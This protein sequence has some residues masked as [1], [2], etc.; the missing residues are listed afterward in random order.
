MKFKIRY[1]FLFLINILHLSATEPT[2][3][4][5]FY[6]FVRNDFYFNSRLNEE[7]IDGI[8]N[9]FPKPVSLN[10]DGKDENAVPNAEMI[11]VG[12]RLGMDYQGKEILGAKTSAKIEADFAGSASTYFLLRIRQAYVQLKWEKSGLLVGQAWHPMFGSVMP[13]M[14]SFNAG[15]PFQP[16][17]RSPQIRYTGELAKNVQYL[18][19]A[20][21][22]MQYTSNGPSG[23]SHT[24]MKN[25][26]IPNLYA[27]IEYKNKNMI[28]GI[29]IDYKKIKPD[30]LYISSLSGNAYIQYSKGMFMA[31]AKAIYGQN[32]SDLIMSGGYGKA[33]DVSSQTY[34]YTNFNSMTGWINLV[35][36]KK[37]QTG[38]FAGYSEILGTG[39]DLWQ[40]NG[41]YTVYGRGFYSNTQE[42]VKHMIRIAPFLSYNVNGIIFGLEYNLTNATFGKLQANGLVSNP[43]Q[44]NNH[45][46]VGLMSYN[47]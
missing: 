28:S 40:S 5:K 39:A 34:Y 8:F 6:G 3:P 41:K 31:K 19:A 18:A 22:Q 33:F 17:N 10:S 38:I 42:M 16:F 12:T 2:S 45:R 9:F 43:Y 13:T 27:G 25:S 15:V 35:Y 23:F 26:L 29:G 1:I 11:S 21:Y 36:G 4:F 24:Y 20:I 14:V 7:V 37:W 30:Q 44:V 46:I 47:F 32:L